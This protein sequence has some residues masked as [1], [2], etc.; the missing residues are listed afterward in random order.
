[1]FLRFMNV[2]VG[3]VLRLPLCV[4]G[5]HHGAGPGHLGGSSLSVP[6]QGKA[7]QWIGKDMAKA[8]GGSGLTYEND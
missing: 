8:C 1:M 7:W 6:W 3:L 5:T 4:R 2:E